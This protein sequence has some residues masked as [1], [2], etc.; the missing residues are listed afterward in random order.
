MHRGW[1][2][3]VIFGLAAIVSS[4][5]ASRP[6]PGP[7]LSGPV[8]TQY[9][10]NVMKQAYPLGTP[11]PPEPTN[12]PAPT[13]TPG[14]H[15]PY[16]PSWIQRVPNAAYG[17]TLLEMLPCE[18]SSGSHVVIIT[19]LDRTGHLLNGIPFLVVG[20]AGAILTGVSGEKSTGVTEVPLSR[21]SWRVY[22]ANNTSDIGMDLREDIDNDPN[23]ANRFGN[24]L[25]YRVNFR[26]V[27]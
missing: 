14:G 11:I 4:A 9:L 5:S 12:T 26:A 8:F 22:V 6:A 2:F 20:A 19:V 21:D 16:D 18:E 23:C 10:P 25:S 3:F 13:R 24:H 1:L 7:V 15:D 27:N 17:I